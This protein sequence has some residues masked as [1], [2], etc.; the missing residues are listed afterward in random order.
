MLLFALANMMEPSDSIKIKVSRKNTLKA[1]NNLTRQTNKGM[2]SFSILE[3]AYGK[4]FDNEQKILFQRQIEEGIFDRIDLTLLLK[5]SYASSEGLSVIRDRHIQQKNGSIKK[6]KEAVPLE[7]SL[8]EE[9]NL[10]AFEPPKTRPIKIKSAAI[11]DANPMWLPLV[12]MFRTANFSNMYKDLELLVNYNK[13]L[14]LESVG[15]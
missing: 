15:K 11:G 13:K 2:N 4:Y 1:L 5:I 3:R 8:A 9:E 6:K 14:C 10:G 7:Y 12:D